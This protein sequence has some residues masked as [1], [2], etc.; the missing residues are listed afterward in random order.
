MHTSYLQCIH[1]RL[2]GGYSDTSRVYRK[3]GSFL[4]EDT[5][6]DCVASFEIAL[7]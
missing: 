4:S 1:L 7:A 2:F 3:S 5:V 6:D